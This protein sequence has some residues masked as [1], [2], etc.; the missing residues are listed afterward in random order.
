MLLQV[1]RNLAAVTLVTPTAGD[2]HATFLPVLVAGST[3]RPVLLGHVAKA[4]T[5]WRDAD[6]DQLAMAIAAG[7]SSYVSPN[8]YPS[9]VTDPQVVPTWN[10]VHVQAHGRLEWIEDHDEKLAIV[11]ELTDH[12]ETQQPRPWAVTD[13]PDEFIASKVRG[14]V[15]LRFHV[16]RLEGSFKLSQNQSDSNRAGV[17]AAL[18]A[19][20]SPRAAGVAD[21]MRARA[22]G[23]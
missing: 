7:P 17:V 14:I 2:L 8:S 12:H 22:G 19:D 21:V 4:N 3:D 10:Y 1:I 9:K 13:A 20:G 15:G 5:Q 23:S 6:P 16:E 18:T 11:S